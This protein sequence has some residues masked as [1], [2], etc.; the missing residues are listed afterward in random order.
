MMVA[1]SLFEAEKGIPK[2]HRPRLESQVCIM[3]MLKAVI[4]ELDAA[5][6]K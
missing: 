3:A 4:D 1:A 6:R 2:K 5:L